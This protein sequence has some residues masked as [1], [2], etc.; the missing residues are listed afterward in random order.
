MEEER[1][2]SVCFTGHRDLP[3]PLSADYRQL[4]RDAGLA[5]RHAYEAGA[6][7]FYTGGAVGFDQ[8]AGELVLLL[9]KKDP[10]VRLI[11]LLPYEGFADTGTQ[12]ER[13]RR[14][15]LLEAADETRTLFPRYFK[16]C[17][18]QRDRALVDHAES[19]IAYLRKAPSGTAWTVSFARKKGIPVV[20][21]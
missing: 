4:V 11:V 17:F 1:L 8:I 9:K 2:Y 6:R 16:G 19:C 12:A 18:L 15:A 14:K 10:S 3:D 5:L 7:D 21:L 13:S 20:L